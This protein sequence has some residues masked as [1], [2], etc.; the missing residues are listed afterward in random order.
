MGFFLS[1]KLPYKVFKPIASR[2]WGNL[3]LSKVFLHDKGYYI[4]NF[5]SLA[6][7]DNILATGPWHVEF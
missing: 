6:D 1:S 2:L 5:N 7:R 4:F 3:G